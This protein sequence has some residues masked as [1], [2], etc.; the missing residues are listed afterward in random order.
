MASL[1]YC[2]IC[3]ALIQKN[4]S[5]F[6]LGLHQV[7]ETNIPSI[8]QDRK[9]EMQDYLI[10]WYEEQRAGVLIFEICKECKEVLYYLFNMKKKERTKILETLEKMYNQE[11]KKK[12]GWGQ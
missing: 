6:L 3:G 9:K 11:P 5:K 7:T 4:D 12:K 2:D 1:T 8:T 10:K